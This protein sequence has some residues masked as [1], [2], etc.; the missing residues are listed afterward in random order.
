MTD[1]T[2][3]A[4]ERQALRTDDWQKTDELASLA[5]A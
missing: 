1:A 2:Q 5:E 4:A 3:V